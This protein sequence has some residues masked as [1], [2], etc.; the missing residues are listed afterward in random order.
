M[1]PSGLTVGTGYRIR[2]DA[3]DPATIGMDNG[4]NL[5]VAAPPSVS[6]SSV[7]ANGTICSGQ[8]AALSATGAAS[9]VWSPAGS[10]DNPNAQNVSATPGATQVYTVV[11][12]NVSGC[13]DTATFIP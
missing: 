10:I 1:I 13:L 8:S 12:A 2:V 9:F 5:I 7:P 4:T 3:S 6:V 11:G